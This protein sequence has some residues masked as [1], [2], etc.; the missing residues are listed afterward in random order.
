MATMVCVS[1]TVGYSIMGNS[2]YRGNRIMDPINTNMPHGL[3]TIDPNAICA[4]QG[5]AIDPNSIKDY[6]KD[7]LLVGCR[8]HTMFKPGTEPN[9]FRW[10][11]WDNS[12][13]PHLRYPSFSNPT[14]DKAWSR[15]TYCDWGLPHNSEGECVAPVLE[16]HRDR[17]NARLYKLSD[18][19][20]KE[21]SRLWKGTKSQTPVKS[22][23]ALIV[24]SSPTNFSH[25]YNTTIDVWLNTVTSALKELGY[26]YRIRDKKGPNA[27]KANQITN[28]ID[29]HGHDCVIANHS[30]GA[31]EA[32]L[33]GVPVVTTSDWNPA[34][35]VS[36]TWEDFVYNGKIK[37]YNK[38]TIEK[39]VTQCCAYTYHREELD[40][41]SWI[42]THPAAGHLR[43][44]L[45]EE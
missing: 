14:G 37:A 39:W 6:S 17:I 16:S 45:I 18:G 9:G 44:Q 3:W 22:K 24:P 15:L 11:W 10:W 4:R 40:M 5:P 2:H 34:R 23:H 30:A 27:R 20:I 43:N 32:V 41:L 1:H 28:E 21:I 36:T 7:Y 29:E 38:T 12:F 19:V 26:T 25:F 31:S 33:H 8:P 13:L 42:T 35:P